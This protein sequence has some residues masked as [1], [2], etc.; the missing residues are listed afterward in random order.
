MVVPAKGM[1]QVCRWSTR[2]GIKYSNVSLGWHV[3]TRKKQYRL[4]STNQASTNLS[5]LGNIHQAQYFCAA[6]IYIN[7]LIRSFNKS[8]IISEELLNDGD[9]TEIGMLGPYNL[10]TH[11]SYDFNQFCR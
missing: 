1:A 8:K 5:S 11:V 2:E 10:Q 6:L 3:A 7:V 9:S 4:I